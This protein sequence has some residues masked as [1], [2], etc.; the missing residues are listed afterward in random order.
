MHKIL[1]KR[2]FRDLR[3]NKFRYLALTLL[4]M[5]S[6]F[7]V[8]SLVCVADATITQ[9]KASDEA[10][11]VEAGDFT[12]FIPL[13]EENIEEI[14]DMDIELEEEFNFDASLPDGHTLRIFRN[15]ERINLLV[16]DTGRAAEA[17][18]EI[19]LEKRYCEENALQTGDTLTIGSYT[20][21]ITGIATTPDYGSTLRKVSDPAVESE[22]FGTAFVTDEG[23]DRLFSDGVAEMSEEYTYAYRL[24]GTATSEDL[25]SYLT[26][27]TIEADQ[28]DDAFFREYWDRTGG[29]VDELT[30]G[31]DELLD[32]AQEMKD[33][34]EEL[35]DNNEKLTDA[36]SEIMDAYLEQANEALKDYDLPETLTA[37]NFEEVLQEMLD[38]EDSGLVRL[39]IRSAKKQLISLKEFS[40]GVTDYTDG[41]SE[42]YDGS[43][44]MLDGVQE[45]NDE[46]DDFI[47]ENLN[48]SLANL[49]SFVEAGDNVR[50]QAASEDVIMNLQGGY[51][52]GVILLI[53]FAYVISVFVIHTINE[54]TS[55]IGAL[56]SLG[57]KR[58]D[59]ILHYIALPA[60]VCFIA[61]LAGT[62]LGISD[63]G[64]AS[65]ICDVYNY[66]SVPIIH[67][68]ASI[69][70]LL[71]GIVMP[72]VLA[73]LVNYIIIRRKLSEPALSLLRNE[74]K[75]GKVNQWKLEHFSF[76]TRFQIRQMLNEMRSSIAIVFGLFLA[77]L[78][79][80]LALDVY[81]MCMNVKTEYVED[82]RFAYMYTY[83]YPTEE[84]PAGGT[85]AYA[86]TL[87]SPEVYGY[88]FDITVLGT[89]ADNPYFDLEDLPSGKN[90]VIISN[91]I[92][93][94]YGIGIGDTLV[95]TDEEEN[96]M[97]AFEV[98][99]I[100]QYSAGMFC[101]MDIEDCR[102]LFDADEDEYN[103]VFADHDL[104]I[105]T[106]RLYAT[107]TRD[108]VASAAA[109]YIDQM[110]SMIIVMLFAAAI[111]FIA[112]I[113]LMSG[114][115]IKRSA[116]A[117]SL[118][119]VFGYRTRDVKKMYLSGNFYVIAVGALIAIPLSKVIMDAIYPYFVCNVAC[120]INL[121]FPVPVYI[122]L[123]AFVLIL[124][125]IISAILTRKL[126][127]IVPAEVLKERE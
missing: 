60:A 123:Y 45:L 6:M 49:T 29:R 5:A 96:E 116:Y 2:V 31:I 89:T 83:K 101:F 109:I 52:A 102:D 91:A 25:K 76:R 18:C 113:Y 14:N 85:E 47:E 103:V 108:D 88:R 107:L 1:R 70:L 7:L 72:P 74:Q 4:I 59:L 125:K 46:T 27:C 11:F 20:Y 44:D 121:T 75:Q 114:I 10:H 95:L 92:H 126:Y 64:F 28:I 71:Y 69:A 68:Q 78:F 93:A 51:F 39:G 17:A 119:K 53:L 58:N 9:T 32:G 67:P 104:G 21:T 94:K 105:E 100:T 55:V 84:V 62:L 77:M 127:K 37:D 97:F 36:A 65:Q 43:V 15:R 16:L 22:I 8:S 122:A 106:G 73:A 61:G 40:D 87:T 124:Y 3:A 54:E 19:V 66:F 81:F 115:M 12:T 90:Q 57:V 38:T 118:I 48:I 117:I 99:G 112:V 35:S 79:A 98:T 24:N 110:I 111:I 26:D 34:L 63:I 23:Y 120:D 42:A 30:D 86:K 56:Y 50:I 33:G 13:S 80:I 41:V 82:T